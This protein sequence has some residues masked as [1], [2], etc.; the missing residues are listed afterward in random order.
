MP[1]PWRQKLSSAALWI[2]PAFNSL[3]DSA[4]AALAATDLV[5]ENYSDAAVKLTYI[6]IITLFSYTQ[7]ISFSG[8]A[9]V[10]NAKET[11][12]IISTRKIPENW[13]QITKNQEITALSVAALATVGSAF[14][15]CCGGYFFIS[16]I[17]SD[18][19]FKDKIRMGAWKGL[20]GVTGAV[21]G[22]TTILT[23]GIGTYKTLR[24]YFSGEKR[25]YTNVVSKWVCRIIG[26][27][28]AFVGACEISIESHASM[29]SL[30][31]PKTPSGKYAIL[32]PCLPKGVGDFVFGGDRCIEAIDSFFGKLEQGW[33]T[34]TEGV[35]F[36]LSAG[37]ATFVANPRRYL[38]TN[39]LNTHATSLPFPMP[40]WA[41]QTLS[42][43]VCTRDAIVQTYTLYPAFY[44]LT[45]KISKSL[46]DTY[47][48][49]R[50]FC[51][52]APNL[53]EAKHRLLLD[54]P[55]D[56]LITIQ[57]END[58]AS[59]AS[60]PLTQSTSLTLSPKH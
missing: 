23:E 1:Y 29:K 45:K 55:N 37:F 53:P 44:V 26:Y 22:M 50:F 33:P 4:I 57:A 30:L 12:K 21:V 28:I 27:P 6:S 31:K 43:G 11:Y 38:T 15:D 36:I 34:K 24:G 13:P 18:Y 41:I 47:H 8:K 14:G 32:I 9:T 17:P 7:S 42:Y 5:N 56:V 60:S 58:A 40:D 2:L 46:L 25:T 3:N 39:L 35:A 19:R 49:A 10:N 16:Q 52:R 51:R 54:P 48:Y 20:A 59:S